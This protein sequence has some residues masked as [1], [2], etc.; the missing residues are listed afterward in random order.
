MSQTRFISMIFLCLSLVV[1]HIHIPICNGLSFIDLNLLKHKEMDVNVMTKRG[2][3]NSIGECLTEEEMDSE[4]NR[5]VLVMGKKYIS[6]ETLK[7]DMVPCDRAG[8]SYYSCH[9]RQENHYSRGCEVIT[10][11]ARGA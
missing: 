9:A 10:R 7:K 8:A 2:C 5:R 11:C 6:Y 4:S 3:G 1:F